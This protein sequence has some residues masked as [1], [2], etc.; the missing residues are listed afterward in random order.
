MAH[1]FLVL[2]SRQQVEGGGDNEKL[3]IEDEG[4]D[5][6]NNYIPSQSDLHTLVNLVV[7][8]KG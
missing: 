6:H 7:S 2:T 5:S 1:V 8:P 4:V 3:N